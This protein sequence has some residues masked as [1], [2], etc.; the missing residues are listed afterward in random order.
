MNPSHGFDTR[1]A[2]EQ[3][4]FCII[5][6]GLV[7]TMMA[8]ILAEKGL[9]VHIYEKRPD[10]RLDDSVA[11]RSI[12]MSLS[13]RGW[14]ALE[15]IGLSR[16]VERTVHPKYGR[17]VHLDGDR[18]AL[19][20]YGR[21]D[22]AISTVNRRQLNSILIERAERSDQVRFFFRHSLD[23]IDADQG[24][25]GLIDFAKGRKSKINCTRVIGADGIF[26]RSR[27]ALRSRTDIGEALDYGYKELTITPGTDGLW[28]QKP[29]FVHVWPRKNL[30]LVALPNTEGSFN[31][32]LIM[33]LRGPVS[34]EAIRDSRDLES[35][36][37]T[38]FADIQPHM[39]DLAVDYFQNPDSK[40]FTVRCHTWH[41]KDR[42]L[43]LGDAAHAIAPFLAMG[44]NVGFED[45]TLFASL[46]DEHPMQWGTIFK[47][48][49]EY[50]KPDTDAIADLSFD[51]LQKLNHSIDADFHLKWQLERR[52]WEAFPDCWTPL[53][54]RIAFSH[55][56]FSH[57]RRRQRK[58][59]D[60]LKPIHQSGDAETILQ[61]GDRGNSLLVQHLDSL[62]PS[63]NS[64]N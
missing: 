5:G 55:E 20:Y 15:R 46:L 29:H 42:L 57:I 56:P 27:L 60:I 40:I 53:Y 50:R 48:F 18:T 19:Q 21:E 8:L 31:C 24:E 23:Y 33:P 6:A 17:I 63:L 45:C 26:S 59:D 44:M 11:G 38:H 22:Q 12:A 47:H 62:Q 13:T 10:I 39:P 35:L 51:N 32:L 52:I 34:F 1:L 25:V 4:D 54:A 37:R 49:S 3:P 16:Q 58:Q 28:A 36:F 64:L 2:G 61:G 9:R 30:L 7:G 41:Y 43:I 14:Q